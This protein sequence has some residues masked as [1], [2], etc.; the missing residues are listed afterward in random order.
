MVELTTTLGAEDVY[1]ILEVLVV[2]AHNDRV[3]NAPK[4]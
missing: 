2:D 4:G 3:M 1:D